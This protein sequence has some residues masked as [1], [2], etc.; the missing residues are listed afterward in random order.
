[1]KNILFLCTGNS[2]RSI[3]AE[4]LFKSMAPA[5]M[6]AQSAGSKP[7]GY[8]HPRALAALQEAGISTDGLHSKSWDN[9]PLPPDIIITLCADAAGETCPAYLGKRAARTHWGM[10]DPAKVQGDKETIEAAFADTLAVLHRRISA[11][12]R[13][14]DKNPIMRPEHLQ[15]ELDALA[16]L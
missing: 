2:C 15:K 1:M 4:A 11:L 7:A 5:G 13:L 16:T 12:V 10:P 14:L 6:T 3:I 9:L 8:V